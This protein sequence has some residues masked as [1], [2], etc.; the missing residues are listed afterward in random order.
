M[1]RE[2]QTRKSDLEYAQQERMK[3][4]TMLVQMQGALKEKETEH[5]QLKTRMSDA[6]V[7]KN[8]LVISLPNDPVP[9]VTNTVFPSNI[10]DLGFPS[11][12]V[13]GNQSQKQTF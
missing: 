1:K 12:F 9:P 5:A 6:P 7:F 8:S 10:S 11:N 13:I 2:K 3:A 4:K